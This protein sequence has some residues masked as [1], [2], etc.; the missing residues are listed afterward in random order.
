MI[1]H[2]IAYRS[3]MTIDWLAIDD[4]KDREKVCE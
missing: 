3:A 1:C 2:R 4:N